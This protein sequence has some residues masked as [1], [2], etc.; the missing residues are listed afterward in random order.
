M[1]PGHH[2]P[3]SRNVWLGPHSIRQEDTV[4]SS[5]ASQ[6]KKPA[7]TK[8]AQMAKKPGRVGQHGVTVCRLCRLQSVMM[9]TQNAD[10]GS[11]QD[12]RESTQ[13]KNTK[14]QRRSTVCNIKS[15]KE[16]QSISTGTLIKKPHG[17]WKQ[18][19]RKTKEKTTIYT[20][21]A[22]RGAGHSWGKQDS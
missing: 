14:P 19:L 9:R 22:T 16:P 15:K 11:R 5:Y 6:T 2:W 10:T 18:T 8:C 3:V 13:G 7:V 21:K 1:L 12:I 20:K 17:T 4:S